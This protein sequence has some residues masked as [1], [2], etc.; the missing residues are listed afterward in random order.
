LLIRIK[1]EMRDMKMD[2]GRDGSV[3]GGGAK[4]ERQSFRSD[5]QGMVMQKQNSPITAFSNAKISEK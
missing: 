1:S 5:E 4:I 3:V 2:T